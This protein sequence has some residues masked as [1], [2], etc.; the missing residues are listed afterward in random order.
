MP[1][2]SDPGDDAHTAPD[3]FEEAPKL[4]SLAQTGALPDTGVVREEVT[5]VLP[6]LGGEEGCPGCQVDVQ[7]HDDVDDPD[8][9]RGDLDEPGD[10]V[11]R[12][13]QIPDGVD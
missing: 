6:P 4:V 13:T 3:W 11:E 9:G 1:D 12:V 8:L 7:V 10:G 5:A 2:V